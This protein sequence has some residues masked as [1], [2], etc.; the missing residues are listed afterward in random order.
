MLRQKKHEIG[1]ISTISLIEV[2][3][4]IEPKKRSKAKELLEESFNHLNI[5][6][7]VI[8]TYCALYDKLKNEGALVP[9]ADLLIAATAITQNIELKTKDEHFKR[10]EKLGLKLTKTPKTSKQA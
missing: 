8:E 9:D 2:L 3:R 1:A 6:N 4:G 5:D 7:P 10:L